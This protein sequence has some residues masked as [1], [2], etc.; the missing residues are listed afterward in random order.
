MMGERKMADPNSRLITLQVPRK[1]KDGLQKRAISWRLLNGKS[2]EPK[3][4]LTD[5]DVL[6]L[7]GGSKGLQLNG[8]SPGKTMTRDQV[9]ELKLT[10]SDVLQLKL[11]DSDVLQLK[12]TDRVLQVKL[13]D[14]DVLQLTDSDVLQLKLTDSDVLQL[15][16]PH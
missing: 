5:S 2:E 4:S 8:V 9:L 3:W 6:Q 1:G 16:W 12:L 10:D 7:V 15:T 11:T 14:S 13:T